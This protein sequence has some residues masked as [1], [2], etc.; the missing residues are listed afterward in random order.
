VGRVDA[1]ENAGRVLS[2]VNEI[3]N[4]TVQAKAVI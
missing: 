2:A 4:T 3:A 1:M